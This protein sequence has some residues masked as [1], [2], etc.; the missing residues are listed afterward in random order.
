MAR[1]RNTLIEEVMDALVTL[2]RTVQKRSAFHW[3]DL[4]LSLAQVKTLLAIGDLGSPSIEQIASMLGVSQPTA[5][6][7]VERVVQSE[8]AHRTQDSQNR[9]RVLVQLTHQGEVLLQHLLGSGV[10]N[11]FATRL[12]YLSEEELAICVQGMRVL[13]NT[14][15]DNPTLPSSTSHVPEK[16]SEN[17]ADV[18]EEPS[19]MHENGS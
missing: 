14:I 9:R 8:L 6:H 5:S 2:L 7:L 19:P 1:T 16:G 12:G 4:D 13:I 11:G 17:L 10:L 18:Q 3:I 15:A